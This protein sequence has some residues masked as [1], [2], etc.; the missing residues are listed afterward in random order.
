MRV[1]SR[2]AS[3]AEREP[4]VSSDSTPAVTIRPSPDTYMRRSAGMPSSMDERILQLVANHPALAD[5]VCVVIVP[6]EPLQAP[7]R[8]FPAVDVEVR[9]KMLLEHPAEQGLDDTRLDAE[10]L[11]LRLQRA[12][13]PRPSVLSAL[14][15]NLGQQ[16]EDGEAIAGVEAPFHMPALRRGTR[17]VFIT[18]R[19]P[20]FHRSRSIIRSSS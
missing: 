12:E 8:H 20:N 3:P 6:I 14:A 7:G 18:H 15:G 10:H 2:A 13:T 19:P 16:R 1:Q 9:V 4:Q 11:A 17:C 5:R